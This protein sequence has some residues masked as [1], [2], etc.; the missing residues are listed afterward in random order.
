MAKKILVIEDERP[1][2][3]ALELKLQHEG[4]EV[5][6]L[7][8]GESAVDAVKKDT[9]DL[10]LLDLMM[11]KMD[12][13]AVLKEFQNQNLKTPTIVISNLSLE[14]DRK[15]VLELGA[16]DLLVKSNTPLAEIVNRINSLLG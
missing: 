11:P 3:R 8:D 4:F 14:V 6:T 16:S 12:G 15:K 2:A 9:Y 10:I 7:H 1:L 5:V 13:F